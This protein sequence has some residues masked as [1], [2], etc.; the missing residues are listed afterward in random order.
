M[1]L[2]F[3]DM[4]SF[5]TSTIIGA[6]NMTQLKTDIDAFDISLSEDVIKEIEG[7]YR[8]YPIPF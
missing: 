8:Q 2:K 7:I 6:T 3:C 4:Q 1:A 5:V